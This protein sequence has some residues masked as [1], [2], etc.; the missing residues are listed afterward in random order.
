MS[1]PISEEEYRKKL[2]NRMLQWVRGE[3]DMYMDNMEGKHQGTQQLSEKVLNKH[4]KDQDQVLK[5]VHDTKNNK[6][7]KLYFRYNWQLRSY[8]RNTYTYIF[9][10]TIVN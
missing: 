2:S 5:K 3:R 7:Y 6:Y 8:L 9:T 10:S 1:K 4:K